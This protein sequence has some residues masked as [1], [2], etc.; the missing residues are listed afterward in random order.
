MFDALVLVLL[1]IYFLCLFGIGIASSRKISSDQQLFLGNRD[2]PWWAIGL[3]VVS[4]YVGAL[5]FVGAPAWSYTEGLSVLL[6]HLNYPL[7][8]IFVITVFLPFFYNSGVPS[9]Y[10]YLESRFG[11]ASRTLMAA[12]FLV[13]NFAYTGVMLYTTALIIGY[14]TGFDL[15]LTIIGVGFLV[16]FYTSSGGITAVVWTD[17]LQTAAFVIGG[18]LVFG[19]VSLQLPDGLINRLGLLER[20]DML[21]LLEF[22]TD[23]SDVS[24][25]WTG[26]GAMSI[27]H[28]VVYGVNQMMVQRTLAAKTIGDA[29]KAYLLMGY[30]ASTIYFIFFAIGVM[31]FAF[32]EGKV[33][34]DNNLILIEFV[35][36]SSVPLITALVA[37]AIVASAM[38]SLDS[39]VN[40]MATVTMVDF[41]KRFQKSD[42]SPQFYLRLTRAFTC[43]W[44]F[45]AVV[46]AILLIDSEG[47]VLELLSKFGSFFVGAKLSL[48]L[49]GFYSQ[50]ATEKGVLI[51]V[52]A[53]FSALLIAEIYF[54][55][56]WPWYALIGGGV[57]I[58]T[59]WFA[60]ILLDGYREEPH[61]FSI[62]GQ[63]HLFEVQGR[64]VQEDGW[65][66]LPGSFDRQSLWL[67]LF[68]CVNILVTFLFDFMY[69]D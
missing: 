9:I 57:S 3:S 46:P 28:I 43:F 45:A 36:A 14:L 55:I 32:Y 11:L 27:Y 15:T 65:Y 68:F 62:K 56:A 1:G 10:D 52:V 26:L 39:S 53:G 23:P 25:I 19:L 16:L 34:E 64:K 69:Q 67:F 48:Y 59:G 44:T 40:S 6:I 13:S 37:V 50:H 42:S 66:L 21:R 12:V 24:T 30:V 20:M 18:I 63:K 2:L 31:L 49:L 33:F 38:S 61:E 29:K 5:S 8:I 17:V 7:A 22:S 41:I 60:S 47:S 54:D 51:G 35:K 58:I 4:T